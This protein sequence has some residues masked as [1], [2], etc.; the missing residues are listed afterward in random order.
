MS[1]TGVNRHRPQTADLQA[2]VVNRSHG[3]A[4]AA[5]GDIALAWYRGEAAGLARA[6]DWLRRHGHRDAAKALKDI[7]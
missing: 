2:G 7:R 4:R 5:N 3:N 1:N 6:V